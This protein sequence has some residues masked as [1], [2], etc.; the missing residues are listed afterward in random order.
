MK[1][2]TLFWD[3]DTQFDFMQPQGK[4]YVPGAETIIPRFWAWCQRGRLARAS[5]RLR[6]VIAVQHCLLRPLF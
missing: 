4:L 3:V 5:E 2:D 6:P 1:E